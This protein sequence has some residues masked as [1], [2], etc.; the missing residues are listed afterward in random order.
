VNV[1]RHE[2]T[3]VLPEA[4]LA[5]IMEA[6]E[7][8]GTAAVERRR[9]AFGTP[10]ERRPDAYRFL[11]AHFRAAGADE[12]PGVRTRP[13]DTDLEAIVQAVGDARRRSELVLVSLHGHEGQA[14]GGNDDTIADFIVD[15]A[16]AA[17]DAGADLFIGHGPHRLHGVEMY[18]GRPIL[19]SLGNFMYMSETVD[20]YPAEMYDAL[21]LPATATPSD[22]HDS[23]A[24]AAGADPV[25][26]HR[27][28]AFWQSVLPVI[29]WSGGA[30]ASV[31]LHPLELGHGLA[32]SARGLA[33]L[34]PLEEGEAILA[35]LD[36]LSRPFGTRI[37]RRR[38]EGRAVG[39]VLLA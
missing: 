29:E 18:R 26:F 1:L 33:R 19:Y 22:V 4:Q 8:L 16:H 39:T 3:Y 11:D 14:G 17:V 28:H 2:K 9:Q 32:R 12:A 35:R 13:S 24:G 36:E 25:G 15:F 23:R 21:G 30:P 27:D 10:P 37:E 5:A 7:S 6:A 20:R 34:A 38:A 31:T